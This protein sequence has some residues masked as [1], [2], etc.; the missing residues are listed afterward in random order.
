V[1]Q[2]S[3]AAEK[4]LGYFAPAWRCKCVLG[5]V[6]YEGGWGK[7]K[8]R[9][10]QKAAEVALKALP[11]AA[12][13]AAAS[14]ASDV[15]AADSSKVLPKAAPRTKAALLMPRAVRGRARR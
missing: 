15:Y 8:W 7:S 3:E 4:Q 9:A 13:A 2:Q 12:P 10:E 5:G 11:A 1:L 6:P 14:A